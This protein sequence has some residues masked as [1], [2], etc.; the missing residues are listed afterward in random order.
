MLEWPW[1]GPFQSWQR[2]SQ[3]WMHAHHVTI[4]IQSLCPTSCCTLMHFLGYIFNVEACN[5]VDWTWDTIV[6]EMV[7]GTTHITY[8]TPWKEWRWYMWGHMPKA[9][10]PTFR[11]IGAEANWGVM[12]PS[13]VKAWGV[14]QKHAV[15]PCVDWVN[16]YSHFICGWLNQF[17]FLFPLPCLNFFLK[18]CSKN[19]WLGS[20]SLC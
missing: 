20:Q 5:V 15:G 16:P 11:I 19:P 1:W 13:Y 2:S 17:V 3:N 14:G 18:I 12:V 8:I 10:P 4:C 7:F 9:R 6:Y